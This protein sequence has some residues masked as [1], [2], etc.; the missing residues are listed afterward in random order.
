ME[1]NDP[2]LEYPSGISETL[3][4][5][6]LAEALGFI[7]TLEM[8]EIRRSLIRAMINQST[9]EVK[10]LATQFHELGESVVDQYQGK[11]YERAQIGLSAAL[12]VIRRDAGRTQHY[13]EDLD[14]M[15]VIAENS[16]NIDIYSILDRAK[17]YEIVLILRVWGDEFG[18]DEETCREIFETPFEEAFES[19]YSY[20]AQ[21]GL[22][23]DEVLKCF[24]RET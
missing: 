17:V 13:I 4:I 5:T 18:F 16:N 9:E 1:S 10:T 22:D 23:A 20:L 24:I 6:E 15:L 7:E 2:K 21:A 8:S 14:E 3:V 11:K 19:A 12:A